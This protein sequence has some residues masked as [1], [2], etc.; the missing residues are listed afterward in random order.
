VELGNGVSRGQGTVVTLGGI[1]EQYFNTFPYA[2]YAIEW[3]S[4]K[5]DW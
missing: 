5:I 4:P 2:Y 3:L 1:A